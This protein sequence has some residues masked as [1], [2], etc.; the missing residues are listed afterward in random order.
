VLTG[1]A[2]LAAEAAE[3]AEELRR[4]QELEQRQQELERRRLALRAQIAGLQADLAALERSGEHL[5][6]RE[7]L[8]EQT[9]RATRAELQRRRQAAPADERSST[10]AHS[11]ASNE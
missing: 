5:L 1:T 11:G 3:H 8:R 9:E 6:E 4:R 7:A 2:R 10:L